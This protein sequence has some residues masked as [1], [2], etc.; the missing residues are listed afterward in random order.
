MAW[1]AVKAQAGHASIESTRI[2]LHLADDL[3]P[4]LPESR[5]DM[6]ADG[7]GAAGH[8]DAHRRSLA[9]RAQRSVGPAREALPC[10]TRDER[11]DGRRVREIRR[12]GRPLP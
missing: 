11:V 2:Y 8:E 3:V 6:P 4:R 9:L 10:S 12:K 5:H 1:E 7:A